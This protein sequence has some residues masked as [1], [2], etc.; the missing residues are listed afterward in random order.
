[1]SNQDQNTIALLQAQI[2][3]LQAQLAAKPVVRVPRTGFQV[4]QKGTLMYTFAKRAGEKGRWPVTLEGHQ[5]ADLVSAI[6][7]GAFEKACEEF[8]A[9]IKA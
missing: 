9:Q 5:W 2:N 1:M 7:A 4:T 3:A 6:K 8:K